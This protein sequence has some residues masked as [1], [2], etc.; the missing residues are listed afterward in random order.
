MLMQTEWFSNPDWWF[1]GNHDDE[2]VHR[3]EHLLDDVDVQD[4]SIIDKVLIWDQ[5]P[6]HIFRNTRSLCI[7][8]CKRRYL[9]YVFAI[10]IPPHT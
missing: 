4:M 10:A 3:F 7:A 9:V 6:R 8:T 1:S 5:L 2:I